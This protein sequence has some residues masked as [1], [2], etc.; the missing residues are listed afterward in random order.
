MKKSYL[1][2]EGGGHYRTVKGKGTALVEPV[3]G[4]AGKP[5]H[6]FLRTVSSF[7]MEHTVEG[8]FQ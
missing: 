7:S 8:S 6:P 2:K 1:S 3:G 4:G 5:S